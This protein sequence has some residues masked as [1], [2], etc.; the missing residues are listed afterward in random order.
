MAKHR[1]VELERV[2]ELG[3][4]LG[5]AFDVHQ[6][7]VRLVHLL[8]RVRHLPA[9][10]VFQAVNPAAMAGHHRAV[11]LDHAGDLL[12]LVGVHDENDFVVTH[13]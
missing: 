6:H 3:Q 11:P 2:L 4:R 13:E 10:P 7:V 9:A 12:A 8:D 5:V 1:V